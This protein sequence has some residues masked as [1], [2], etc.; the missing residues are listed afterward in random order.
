MRIAQ[1]ILLF[2]AGALFGYFYGTPD[3]G[4]PIIEVVARIAP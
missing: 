1:F 3:L 4:A 2:A